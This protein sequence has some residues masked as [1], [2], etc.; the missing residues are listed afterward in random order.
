MAEHDHPDTPPPDEAR[1]KL[2]ALLGALD[3]ELV[4]TLGPLI[5]RYLQPRGRREGD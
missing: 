4:V 1:A 5:V 2:L 3:A